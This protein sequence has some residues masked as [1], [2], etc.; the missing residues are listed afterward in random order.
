MKPPITLP[1]EWVDDEMRVFSPGLGFALGMLVLTM[2][3]S[4]LLFTLFQA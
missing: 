3:A 2:L 1:P 4:A